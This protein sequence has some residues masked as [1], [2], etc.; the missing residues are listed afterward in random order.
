MITSSVSGLVLT[1]VLV[2]QI[3]D[4]PLQWSPSGEWITF[5]VATPSVEHSL[6]RFPLFPDDPGR[7][8]T[9]PSVIESDLTY[10]IW[11]VR[12]QD[13]Q[14]VKIAESSEPMTSPAWGPDGKGIAFGRIVKGQGDDP[15]RWE[16]VI[17]YESDH[18]V[19]ASR[20]LDPACPIRDSILGES[21]AWSSD[22]KLLAVPDPEQFAVELITVERGE[23]LRRIEDARLLAFSPIESRM[24]FYRSR[25]DRW[26][27]VE[28]RSDSGP[29][30]DRPIDLLPRVDQAPLWSSD[31]QT[32]L[33]LKLSPQA[34]EGVQTR[35]FSCRIGDGIPQEIKEVESPSM[36][37]EK[38]LGTSFSIADDGLDQYFL[39]QYSS[40]PVAISFHQG[41]HPLDRFHPFAGNGMLGALNLSPDRD[42]L[43]VRFA[44]PGIQSL[45]GLISIPKKQLHPLVPDDE[46]KAVWLVALAASVGAQANTM[47][48]PTRL[49]IAAE[50][51]D[52]GP[53]PSSYKRLAELGHRLTTALDS[54]GA[55]KATTARPTLFFSYLMG[56]Y[57]GA[58]LALGDVVEGTSNPDEAIRLLGLQ[59]QLCLAKGNDSEAREIL[60]FVKQQY[61]ERVARVE[62]D[63]SGGFRVSRDGLE[64]PSWPD[65]LWKLHRNRLEPKTGL[66]PEPPEA[67][68][69]PV[70]PFDDSTIPGTISPPD[71][72]VRD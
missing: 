36:P 66:R 16:V 46:L 41:S 68:P 18:E 37:G 53:L 58:N 54:E 28:S 26:E 2:A 13:R 65:E 3:A 24:A 34:E 64:V 22:G 32:L 31:G 71:F 44:G 51:S 52:I 15:A 6:A 56:D 19:I 10:R 59:A 39:V 8:G 48:R 63:G 7:A 47:Q 70:S 25:G 57:D 21:V 1:W 55:Q 43:A 40:R 33:Y 42:Q 4:P 17:A 5:V 27:L 67:P 62:P 20:E 49:P 14:A 61:R 23:R 29:E 9:E 45:P 69:Q 50:F 38:I 60:T 12:S 11:A 72:N 35:F 30:A